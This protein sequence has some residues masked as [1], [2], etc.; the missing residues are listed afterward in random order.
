MQG[1]AAHRLGQGRGG[2]HDEDEHCGQG[3][4]LDS[5]G[6]EQPAPGGQV[7][8]HQDAGHRDD[9]A[10]HRW[11]AYGQQELFEEDH[12]QD[13]DEV[14]IKICQGVGQRGGVVVG[15]QGYGEGQSQG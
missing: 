9:E 7:G 15:Q 6:L 5:D 8:K 2:W 12:T 1:V 4:H 13:E 11:H 10:E 3:E 14:L